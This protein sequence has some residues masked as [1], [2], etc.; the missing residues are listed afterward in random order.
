MPVLSVTY[1]YVSCLQ[2]AAPVLEEGA[3]ELAMSRLL[4]P[5]PNVSLVRALLATP[6]S[7]RPIP[8]FPRYLLRDC[9]DGGPLCEVLRKQRQVLPSH[10]YT[11]LVLLCLVQ[12]FTGLLHL[13]QSGTCHR[14]LGLDCIHTTSCGSHHLLRITNLC[15]ALHRPG[16]ITATTF[17]YGYHELKWLGGADSRLPPEIMNTPE[18]AQTLDYGH[19]DCF[20]AGCLL[21]EMM[22]QEN[23]FEQDADLVYRQYSE[24]DLP[25]VLP[26]PTPNPSHL[27]QLAELLLHR[28]P[29]C[30]LATGT[31][32]LLT[33]ALLW[34][35]QQWI[36]E[37]ISEAQ[38]RHHLDYE[39][40]QLVAALARDGSA[41]PPLPLLLKARFLASCDVLELIR[42]LSLFNHL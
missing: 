20:A 5:H 17:V 30:R 25:P 1:R 33:Q 37:P 18:N 11:E 23:P 41:S 26:G 19:T 35:P 4:E 9:I 12:V 2:S 14:D 29:A 6:P 10:E 21:Y 36:S 16:P 38:V 34:L 24:Q 3:R 31:A 28:L 13:Y 22:G 39:R 32:L 42:A 27:Q 40:A 7:L 8:A 15:Y